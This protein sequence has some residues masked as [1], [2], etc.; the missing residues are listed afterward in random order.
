MVGKDQS[1]NPVDLLSFTWP[2]HYCSFKNKSFKN[3]GVAI[4]RALAKKKK[5]KKISNLEFKFS[6]SNGPA[7]GFYDSCNLLSHTG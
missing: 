7:E 1:Y 2:S 5:K 4:L 6:V 3:H